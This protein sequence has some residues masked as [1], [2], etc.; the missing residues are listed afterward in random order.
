MKPDSRNPTWRARCEDPDTGKRTKVRLDPLGAGKNAQTRRQWAIAMAR[1]IAKRRDALSSGAPRATGT[2][3]EAAID[4]Y[5][6]DHP[7]LRERT[8]STYKK[9]TDKLKAW[10]GARGIKS[11]DALTLAHLVAFRSALANEKRQRQ[12][13]DGKRGAREATDRARTPTAVNVE[14]RSVKVAL[15]YLRKLGLL[16]KL[17]RDDLSDGLKSLSVAQERGVFL[18]PPDLRAL[19]TAAIAHDSETFD[20]TREEHAG[21]RPKGST[22][23]YQPIAPLVAAAMLT[24]MRFGEL[25]SL[26]WSQVDLPAGEIHL[27]AATKTKRARTIDLEVSPALA[28]LLERIRP[29]PARGPVFGLTSDA[30]K[31]AAKRLSN[32]GAP[33][34]WTWQ[35]LRRTCGTFLT[36]APGIFGAASAYRSARQLGH[37]VAIA[38]RHYV[39]VVKVPKEATTLEEA[40]GV[41]V[42]LSVVGARNQPPA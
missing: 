14:I 8:R 26:Q 1:T 36:C 39:G 2:A 11:A 27:S 22:P 24:G 20:A 3:L 7:R 33:K 42:E 19:L 6:D 38:E 40:M 23:R 34:G 32:Y 17:T 18:R 10:C 15:G 31:A 5:F 25:A 41:G 30:M 12:A 21:K 13:K 9:G 37:S 16:P 35:T 4:R 28:A 29:T